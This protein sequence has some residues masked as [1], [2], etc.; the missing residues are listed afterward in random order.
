MNNVFY[1]HPSAHSPKAIHRKVPAKLHALA[2]GLMFK[3]RIQPNRSLV[4]VIGNGNEHSNHDSIITWISIRYSVEEIESMAAPLE[5][6]TKVLYQ[7][8][9]N[10][11][12]NQEVA[13][14]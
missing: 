6:L 14:C 9:D 5:S 10:A 8:L 3:L 12:N 4:S 13:S 7:F 2:S 1:L 11:L